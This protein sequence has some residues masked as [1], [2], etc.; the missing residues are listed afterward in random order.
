MKVSLLLICIGSVVWAAP[1]PLLRSRKRGTSSVDRTARWGVLAQCIGY[2]VLWQGRFWLKSPSTL[3]VVAAVMCFA[4]GDVLSWWSALA[5]GKNFRVDA[6][7]DAAHT[8]VRSGPYRFVR[9]PIY[10][11]MLFILV[12]TGI[13]IAP[14]YLLCVGALLF[15]AG[16][17]IRVHTEDRLLGSRFGNTFPDYRDQV[18]ALVPLLPTMFRKN[19]MPERDSQ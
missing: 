1:Y 6:A 15:L 18:P 4:I 10:V 19:Q 12:A 5:L 13:L 16:T 11:S 8:L 14:W 7:V 2:S 17:A 9:H 3:L